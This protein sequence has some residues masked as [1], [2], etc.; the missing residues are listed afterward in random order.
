M[1]WKQPKASNFTNVSTVDRD[2]TFTWWVWLS[3]TWGGTSMGVSGGAETTLMI[4]TTVANGW[5]T[6]VDTRGGGGGGETI[7]GT[8]PTECG[9]EEGGDAMTAVGVD[10]VTKEMVAAVTLGWEIVGRAR[11]RKRRKQKEKDETKSK[12][13]K[14]GGGKKREAAMSQGRWGTG[15]RA[16]K[17]SDVM[18]YRF[19][20]S[21]L[22]CGTVSVL[23]L[24]CGSLQVSSRLH[25]KRRN[26]SL[27]R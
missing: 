10:R 9:R 7:V 22:H 26:V 24:N 6:G 8:T 2:E 25:I 17:W 11:E 4:G 19:K 15:K 1:Q 5:G 23:M 16:N 14:E 20:I 21:R 18:I 13:Y 12:V 27:M 3:S